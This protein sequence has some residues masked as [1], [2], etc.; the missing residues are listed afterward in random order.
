MHLSDMQAFAILY[1]VY[2]MAFMFELLEGQA[3]LLVCHR[4]QVVF[5]ELLLK[6]DT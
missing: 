3:K 2:Q 5:E 6:A 1:L 4:F